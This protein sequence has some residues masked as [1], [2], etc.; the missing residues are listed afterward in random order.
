VYRSHLRIAADSDTSYRLAQSLS[1][2]KPGT[3]V[4]GTRA[5]KSSS[6]ISNVDAKSLASLSISTPSR[7]STDVSVHRNPSGNRFR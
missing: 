7:A 3:A 1:S 4:A 2:L 5:R 6:G